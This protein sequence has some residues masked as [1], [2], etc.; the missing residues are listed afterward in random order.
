MIPRTTVTMEQK[1]LGCMATPPLGCSLLSQE[2]A[3]SYL[4][5]DPASKINFET[6]DAFD[7]HQPQSITCI[8]LKQF[9]Q[10]FSIHHEIHWKSPHRSTKTPRDSDCRFV[11][12][13][14]Y[15]CMAVIHLKGLLF[16]LD[17]YSLKA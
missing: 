9:T 6:Q 3:M 16:S 7:L 13:Q 14:S 11:G 10:S 12:S 17:P 1:L 2:G 15:V 8:I 5:V 4:W